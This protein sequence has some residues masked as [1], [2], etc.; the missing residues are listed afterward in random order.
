MPTTTTEPIDNYPI[1]KDM[2]FK[3]TPNHLS[4]G[5]QPPIGYYYTYLLFDGEKLVYIGQTSWTPRLRAHLKNG[6]VFNSTYA[7]P[8]KVRYY[9]EKTGYWTTLESVLIRM[10]RTKY[11]KCHKAKE[12][13]WRIEQH[14]ASYQ[15]II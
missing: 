1:L 13:A 3:K 5:G 9:H 12:Q 4:F 6:K 14:G 8:T 7:M 11:N 2:G 10:Y 15:I